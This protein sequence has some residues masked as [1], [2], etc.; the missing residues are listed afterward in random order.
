MQH[1]LQTRA[2]ATCSK[3]AAP[4]TLAE[5]LSALVELRWAADEDVGRGRGDGADGGGHGGRGWHPGL[6]D[7]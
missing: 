2:P 6:P 3:H 1:V 4:N 7:D 5:P